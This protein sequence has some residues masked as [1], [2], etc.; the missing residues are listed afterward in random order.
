MKYS[1]PNQI[2]VKIHKNAY[3]R[4]FMQVGIDEWTHAF[5]TLTKSGFGLYLYLC[6][7]MDGFRLALSSVDVQRTLNIS[8]SSYRRAK[9][10]LLEKGYLVPLGNGKRKLG[11]RP[12]LQMDIQQSNATKPPA[13]QYTS[14]R[15]VPP[16]V[17][18]SCYGWD[19]EWGDNDF[20]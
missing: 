17:D 1:F 4:D 14:T 5:S 3:E 11:F 18:P 9:N 12:S 6:G 13:P 8:D 19:I 10:E 16:P 2:T 7:N 20:Q 15:R